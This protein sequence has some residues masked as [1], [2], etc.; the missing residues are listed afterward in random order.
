M[1]KTQ[2][3]LDLETE[4]DYCGKI[5]PLGVYNLLLSIRDMKMFCFGMKPNARWRMKDVKTYFGV[6]GNKEK[7]LEQ[8]EEMKEPFFK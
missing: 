3:E 8:L 4:L 7:V 5:I 2:F 1:T 6:K